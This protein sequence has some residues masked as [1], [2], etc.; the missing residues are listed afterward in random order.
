MKNIKLYRSAHAVV[1]LG[2]MAPIAALCNQEP[3]SNNITTTTKILNGIK[4][5]TGSKKSETKTSRFKALKKWLTGKPLTVEEKKNLRKI[6][7]SM[8]Q[9]H[10]PELTIFFALIGST[11]VWYKFFISNISTLLWK[12]SKKV[13]SK[14]KN[15]SNTT[16]PNQDFVQK[17]PPNTPP[18]SNK[19]NELPVTKPI[20]KE[21]KKDHAANNALNS[22]NT[23][24]NRPLPKLP[25]EQKTPPWF[26]RWFQ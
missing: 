18:S 20:E 9:S 15:T 22:T 2:L 24:Q 4:Q 26:C 16:P 1:L 17:D 7:T 5:K 6:K 14:R 25:I 12:Q 21:D 11:P 19:L 10:I 13:E 23:Q 3:E 8:H